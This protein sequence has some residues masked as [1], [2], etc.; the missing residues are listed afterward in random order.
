MASELNISVVALSNIERGVTDLPLSRL[1]DIATV[2]RISINELI[3][4]A[5]NVNRIQHVIK[6]I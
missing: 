5:C 1:Y 6:Y 4:D 3:G 2:L